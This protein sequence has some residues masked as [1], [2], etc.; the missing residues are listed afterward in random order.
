MFVHIDTVLLLSLFTLLKD[1][2]SSQFEMVALFQ[3]T[4]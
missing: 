2:K 1:K 3:A 4:S